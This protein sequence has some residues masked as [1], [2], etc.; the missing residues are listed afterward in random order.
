MTWLSHVYKHG[1]KRCTAPQ[2]FDC[3]QY[4]LKCTVSHF[5]CLQHLNEVEERA[6]EGQMV[7]RREVLMEPMAQTMHAELVSGQGVVHCNL[8]VDC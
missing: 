6:V 4:Y 1:P 2:N 8:V 7:K 5:S 3:V